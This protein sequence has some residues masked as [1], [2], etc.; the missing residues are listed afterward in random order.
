M[1]WFVV[2]AFTLN[3]PFFVFEEVRL[4]DESMCLQRGRTGSDEMSSKTDNEMT[5][6][7]LVVKIKSVALLAGS[8]RRPTLNVIGALQV[9]SSSDVDALKEPVIRPFEVTTLA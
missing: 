3:E 7:L 9:R 6:P 8:L 5:Y 2:M 1:G 4:I